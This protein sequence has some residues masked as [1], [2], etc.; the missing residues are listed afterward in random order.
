MITI[1]SAGDTITIEPIDECVIIRRA[2]AG[3]D[4]RQWTWRLDGATSRLVSDALADCCELLEGQ[5]NDHTSEL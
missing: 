2:M 1:S 5:S 4:G 3:P